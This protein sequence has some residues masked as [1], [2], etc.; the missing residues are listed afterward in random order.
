MAIIDSYNKK[1]G[2]TYVY[3]SVSY[4]DKELKQPR[5]RRRLLGRRDPSTGEIVPTR[6]SPCPV[7]KPAPKDSS[8]DYASL[9]K[10]SQQIIRRKDELIQR[11]RREL[12]EARHLL[13]KQ[14]RGIARVME[15]LK[16]LEPSKEPLHA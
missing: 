4:W 6:K 3:E 13:Q 14:N 5:S 15:D 2:V 10:R 7:A 8:T 11:L 16:G 1:R 12:A 9:Y